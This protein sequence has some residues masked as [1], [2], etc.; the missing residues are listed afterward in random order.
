MNT[1]SDTI[2]DNRAAEKQQ[3]FTIHPAT[4]IC[5]GVVFSSFTVSYTCQPGLPMP[6]RLA[7]LLLCVYLGQIGLVL[8]A[9]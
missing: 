7:T 2:N 5:L 4:F 1:I 6:A 8:R 9:C 3:S